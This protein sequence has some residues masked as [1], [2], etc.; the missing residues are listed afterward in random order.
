MLEIQPQVRNTEHKRIMSILRGVYDIKSYHRRG[1][2]HGC[3]AIAMN[4]TIVFAKIVNF[5]PNNYFHT[6]A[7]PHDK[8]LGMPLVTFLLQYGLIPILRNPQFL[9]ETTH[10][11][12]SHS[13]LPQGPQRLIVEF[14]R[15]HASSCL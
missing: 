11:P 7:P 8:I 1:R 13:S 9:L 12:R 14:P 6:F 2:V 5:A 4:L 15:K 10:P 3:I